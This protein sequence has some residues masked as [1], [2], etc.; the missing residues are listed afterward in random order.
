MSPKDLLEFWFSPKGRIDRRQLALGMLLPLFGV[1]ILIDLS[2]SA[3]FTALAWAVIAWPLF[4]ATPWKRL[5]DQGRTGKWNLVFLFAYLI[6]FVFLLGEYAAAEGGWAKL[7][8]GQDPVTTDDDLTANGLG[9]F[10]TILIFLPIHLFWLYLIPSQRGDNR[11][12]PPP[13]APRS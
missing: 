12:G 13:R 6:G 2:N 7:F 11:Y 5:H 9:G 8:D 1:M 3:V 10:S 4:I